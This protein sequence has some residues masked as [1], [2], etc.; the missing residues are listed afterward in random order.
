M[1][2][3][4]V[5]FLSH[6]HQRADLIEQVKRLEKDVK[7]LDRIAKGLMLAWCATASIAV[8]CYLKATN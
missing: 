1:A 6:Y 2:Q 4:M 8:Y 7:F 3:R 5:P